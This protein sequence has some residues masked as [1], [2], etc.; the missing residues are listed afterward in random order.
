MIKIN[1]TD[2]K[3]RF[4]PTLGQLI[5][6]DSG[7]VGLVMHVSTMQEVKVCVLSEM[8]Y[9]SHSEMMARWSINHIKPFKGIVTITND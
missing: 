1:N 2:V 9:I 7:K 8:P 4:I 3:E 5:E 6:H